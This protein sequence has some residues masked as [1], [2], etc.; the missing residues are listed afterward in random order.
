MFEYDLRARRIQ[1]FADPNAT[2]YSLIVAHGSHVRRIHAFA[3][4]NATLYSLVVAH[5][6]RRRERVAL[7]DLL[8]SPLLRRRS[9]VPISHN[10]TQIHA[11]AYNN[12]YGRRAR[13]G[14]PALC[15]LGDL[16]A[17]RDDDD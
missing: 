8:A 10:L 9:C 15:V 1:T 7:D 5:G 13:V 17:Y 16:A 4:P 3:D 11:H 6:S 14:S 12:T 2:L